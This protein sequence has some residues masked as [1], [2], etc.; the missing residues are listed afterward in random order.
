M[1][2]S[3]EIPAEEEVRIMLSVMAGEVSIA[4]VARRE[5]CSEQSITQ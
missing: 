2:R 4:E 3:P 5:K 1:G